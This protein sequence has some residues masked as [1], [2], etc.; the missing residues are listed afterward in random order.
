MKM[1]GAASMICLLACVVLLLAPAFAG[2]KPMQPRV[3]QPTRFGVS[4]PLTEIAKT[5]PAPVFHGWIVRK[6]H[7]PRNQPFTTYDIKDPVQQDSEGAEKLCPSRSGS[8]STASTGNRREASY[9]PIPMGRSE[10]N[11]FS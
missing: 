9:R 2:D 5:T 11:S 8:I 6:E 7:E 4:L 1:K 10:I 3:I